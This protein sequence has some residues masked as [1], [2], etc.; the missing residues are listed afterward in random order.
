MRKAGASIMTT[1]ATGGYLLP[2]TAGL[3]GGLTLEQFIQT[4]IVG[5]TALDG[6]LVRPN[7]QVA[8]PKMP[9]LS[10]DWIAFGVAINQPDA[11]AYVGLDTDG[12][13]DFQRHETLEIECAIYGPNAMDNSTQLR[14]G[15]EIQQNLEALTT[16][17]MGFVNTTNALHA[18]ELINERWFN[19][20]QMSLIIRRE[21]LR[22]YPVLTFVS[23]SG[24]I[25]AADTITG[26]GQIELDFAVSPPTP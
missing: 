18:P 13:Y 25:I 24:T 14:D 7:W 17:S 19:R 8:P 21:I 1:S 2:T 15:F 4:V 20:Y 5:M 22:T 26:G 23:A 12:N 9:D 3:P 16:A 11:N 6:T 10:V